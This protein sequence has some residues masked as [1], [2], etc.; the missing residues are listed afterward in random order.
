MLVFIGTKMLLID[1]YKIPVQY[2]LLGTVAIL[3]TTMVLSV[4]IKPKA[5]EPK[6][7]GAYPFG[8][9]GDGH[10]RDH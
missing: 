4:M 1:L 8:G 7:G 10:G 3:G 6:T 5:D 9:K 2:S